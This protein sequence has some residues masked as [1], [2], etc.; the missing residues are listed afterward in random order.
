MPGSS[1]L[2]KSDWWLKPISGQTF[3]V[4]TQ[5]ALLGLVECRLSIAG[6]ESMP[7]DASNWATSWEAHQFDPTNLSGLPNMP[8]SPWD[9]FLRVGANVGPAAVPEPSPPPG[10]CP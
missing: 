2:F 6:P 10:G 3:L 7:A 9:Y 8:N 5:N 4:A 1:V